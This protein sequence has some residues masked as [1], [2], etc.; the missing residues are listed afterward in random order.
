MLSSTHPIHDFAAIQ[1][2]NTK[3]GGFS[4]EDHVQLEQAVLTTL[5]VYERAVK[6]ESDLADRRDMLIAFRILFANLQS[7]VG[8]YSSRTDKRVANAQEIYTR[9]LEIDSKL[10]EL[11][12]I[13]KV[14][15]MTG[16]DADE[17]LDLVQRSEGPGIL[18]I[19][20]QFAK[21]VDAS[22]LG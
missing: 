22:I 15:E 14:W 10:Q 20:P 2:R 11:G 4:R 18:K 12:V 3:C 17:L 21:Q 1:Y 19:T 13:G 16:E 9:V 7:H 5:S 8:D 6:S